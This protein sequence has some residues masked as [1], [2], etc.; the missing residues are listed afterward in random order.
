MIKTISRQ[1]NWLG[2]AAIAVLCMATGIAQAQ[3][4]LPPTVSWSTYGVGTGSYNE[5]VAQAAGIKKRY[6]TDLRLLPTRNDISKIAPLR[7][8]AVDFSAMGSGVLFT[9]EGVYDFANQ[10]WGPQKVMLLG[11]NLFPAHVGFFTSAKGGIKQVSDLRGKRVPYVRGAPTLQEV[12]RGI[13]AFGGLTFKDVTLVEVA[14]FIANIQAFTQGQTDIAIANTLSPVSKRGDASPYGP[15]YW[16]PFPH[17]DDAAWERLQKILPYAKKIVTSQGTRIPKNFQGITYALPVLIAYDRKGNDIV[18]NMTKA[19]F[20]S[21]PDY[22]DAL[23]SAKGWRLTSD[24]FDYPIPVHPGAVRFY[25][26]KGLWKPEDDRNNAKL[27]KRQ[28]VLAEAWKAA[29]TN[30]GMADDAFRIAWLRTRADYLEKAGFDPIW[31]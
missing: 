16:P 23:A 5:A 27:V 1:F 6:R 20:E 14:G 11:I 10:S 13:L 12:M 17:D 7:S 21:Y 3:V 15:V 22:K 9:Q 24:S 19:V 29:I 28:Q 4:K 8:G 31:R 26:E 30:K 18:Y 2:A 25:K